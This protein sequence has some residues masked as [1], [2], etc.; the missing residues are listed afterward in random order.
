MKAF[1]MPDRKLESS[2]VPSLQGSPNP[3]QLQP[4]GA[5]PRSGLVPGT[6]S[7]PGTLSLEVGLLSR[8]MTIFPVA[9]RELRV[10][11]RQPRTYD[12]RTLTAAVAFVVVG[13]ASVYARLLGAGTGGRGLFLSGL[14]LFA[15][16]GLA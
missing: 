16:W 10:A 11:A 5:A 13:Y 12:I 3:A 2:H 8:P 4:P 6:W 14:S 9:Q 1:G 7:F 15:A